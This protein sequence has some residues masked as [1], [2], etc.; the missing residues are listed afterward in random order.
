M[1]LAMIRRATLTDFWESEK[2]KLTH[3]FF[4]K[5]P[6]FCCFLGP[7]FSER[8]RFLLFFWL[9]VGDVNGDILEIWIEMFW[10]CFV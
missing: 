10:S 8:T 1:P 6:V 2:A 3:L 4:G 9:V 7:F 5:G